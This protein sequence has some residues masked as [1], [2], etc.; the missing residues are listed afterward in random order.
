MTKEAK[1]E[2]ISRL[3]QDYEPGMTIAEYANRILSAIE[4]KGN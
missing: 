4:R 2:A 3:L 1:L